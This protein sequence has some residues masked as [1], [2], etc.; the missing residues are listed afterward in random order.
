[1]GGGGGKPPPL[2]WDGGSNLTGGGGGEN[3]TNIGYP[4]IRQE[5]DGH[6]AITGKACHI[7]RPDV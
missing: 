5:K 7:I 4:V 1:M 6:P 3:V 2:F